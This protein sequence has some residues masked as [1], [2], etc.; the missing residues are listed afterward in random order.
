MK[1][2]LLGARGRGELCGVHFGPLSF[3]SLSE[4]ISTR[5]RI[6]G[7]KREGRYL[8]VCSIVFGTVIF[9]EPRHK[10]IGLVGVSRWMK[11]GLLRRY[12]CRWY[13][14][15]YIPFS[16]EMERR[17][18]VYGTRFEVAR[19]KRWLCPC[20]RAI[21]VFQGRQGRDFW[22]VRHLLEFRVLRT[23]GTAISIGEYE[24]GY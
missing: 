23:A 3:S 15:V 17:E 2:L 7:K 24:Y 11:W 22:L 16:T 1:R 21:F 4:E 18:A 12:R 5:V 10:L 14:G 6:E 8:L 13:T 20:Q 9:V 19:H